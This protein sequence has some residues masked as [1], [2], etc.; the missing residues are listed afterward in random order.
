MRAGI[1]ASTVANVN[2][3]AKRKKPYTPHDFMPRFDA[4]PETAEEN[5]Q[6]MMAQMQAALGGAKTSTT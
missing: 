2:R 4:E 3:P 5:A 1:V 6:R